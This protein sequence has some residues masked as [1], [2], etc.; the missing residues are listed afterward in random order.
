MVQI[1]ARQV[2]A[3]RAVM[4]TGGMTSAAELLGITQPAVS[5]LVRDFEAT[6]RLLLFERRGNQVVPT[7]DA[8]ALLGEVERS[9]VGL[10]RIAEVAR[11]IRIQ[12]AG[13]LRVAAMPALATSV[14]PHFAG[15]FLRERPNVRLSIQGLA[16]HA[17]IEAVAAGQA[18]FGYAVGP[19]ER[20]GFLV[21]R[22][23]C[24]AVVIMP[25]GHRLARKRRLQPADLRGERFITVASGTLLHSRIETVLADV[26]RI[27]LVE[28]P[29]SATACVLVSEGL[30]ISV[31]DPFSAA[32][33]VGRGLVSRPLQPA[34]DVGIVLLRLPHRPVT[35]LAAKFMDGFSLHLAS[36]AQWAAGVS[37]TPASASSARPI[38]ARRSRLRAGALP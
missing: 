33:F 38:P 12:A 37:E 18:E 34:V 10:A 29:L 3:F 1:N 2:E 17:V 8:V 24:C 35:P 32:E 7:Q 9:F 36:A 11:A 22:L 25:E 27:S 4:L 6:V 19:L 30:G 13:S 26:E 20:P 31:V 5:R 14:L 16:S 15:R 23:P 21:E 28:T